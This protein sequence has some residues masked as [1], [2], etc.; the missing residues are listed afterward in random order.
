MYLLKTGHTSA[1][2]LVGPFYTQS[3]ILSKSK[4]GPLGDATYKIS[5]I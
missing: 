3:S 2:P 1:A 4:Y 5:G